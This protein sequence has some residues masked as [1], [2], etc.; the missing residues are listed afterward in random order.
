M[1][2][3]KLDRSF[4]PNNKDINYLNKSFPQFRQSLIDFARAYFPDS[5]NDFNEASPGM[6][7]IEM[8]SYV[9]D[10]LSYYTDTQFRENLLQYAQEEDN[11][12]FIAQSLGYKPKPTSAS[13]VN[14]DVYQLVPALDIDDD[15]RPDPN[16]M[17]KIA[18]GMVMSSPQYNVTFRTTELIDFSDPL[19]REVT[20][21]S[22]DGIGKPMMYLVRKTV[23]ATAGI[24]KTF[25]QTFETPEKFSKIVLPDENVIEVISV[26]DDSGFK[27]HEVD[28]LAQDI[29]FEDIIN[30]NTD[31]D[32]GVSP[33]FVI[34]PRRT[35]R[36][37]VTRYNENFQLELHF[38]SGVSDV[39]TDEFNL[40]PNK[41]ISDEY[42]V[43]LASTA[44]D[45][46]DF[47]D[48][49]TYG[50][51]PGN[52]QMTIT[53]SIGGGI[54]SNVPSNSINKI[55]IIS[56]LNDRESYP[57][58][59]EREL[60]DDIVSSIAINNSIPASGGRGGDTIEEIRQNALA[61]F[62][63]QN[64]LVTPEDYMA[65]C[66]AMPPKYGGVA[67][68]FVIRD[69]QINNVL[70]NNN[71]LAPIGGE[72]VENNVGPNI[73]N[74]YVLGYD[75]R[76]KLARL[77][78]DTK[79]NLKTYLE[80]YRILTDEIRILDAFVINIGVDFRIVVYQG[81]NVNE[82]LARAIDSVKNFFDIDR[83]K[84][85]QPIVERDLMLEIAKLEGVQ[86][87]D[88]L[89][90]FNRYR[91]KDGGDYEDYLY[92][93]KSATDRG[94]IYPSLDPSI[95]EIRYPDKDIIGSAIQ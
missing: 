88:S 79:K 3:K 5:Y 45:P 59:P 86:S 53:Y 81:Y 12:I 24:V 16:Y 13:T 6:M 76:K 23:R 93:I 40:D 65:R 33:F 66:F 67:K 2:N 83:W 41:I 4:I 77:N 58:G 90:V 91:H 11:I 8:A 21:Y 57:D 36:R 18:P 47:L 19:S 25:T 95:F 56:V 9:G 54:G 43:N 92:D 74:L 48:N 69:E 31:T 89:K 49:K 71:D 55:D 35:P 63:S 17:L 1:P 14:V 44:L 46:S 34:R 42:E 73:V 22:V 75:H 52:T 82:T 39:D 38:G 27:W 72:F 30:R 68:A 84:I 87:V 7:F 29:V 64:R 51:A 15:Y 60:Y 78:P 50:L 26:V 62:N 32:S 61:F 10:V 70:R 80:N 37:F 20:V 85:N 94:I 28:Y